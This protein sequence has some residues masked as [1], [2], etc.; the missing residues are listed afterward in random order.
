MRMS[1][2]LMI[3]DCGY[4][5]CVCVCVCVCVREIV[6]DG[7]GGGRRTHVHARTHVRARS[8]HNAQ[9]VCLRVHCVAAPSCYVGACIGEAW[10]PAACRGAATAR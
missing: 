5:L 4:L 9:R 10:P 2:C 8:L 1:S 7:G 3:R 6:V